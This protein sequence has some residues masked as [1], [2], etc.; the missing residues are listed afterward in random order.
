MEVMNKEKI[1]KL[2][3]CTTFWIFTPVKTQ[4]VVLWAVTPCSVGLGTDV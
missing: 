2:H 1:W 4:F 3:I